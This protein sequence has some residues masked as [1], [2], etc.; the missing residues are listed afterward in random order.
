MTQEV[1][2]RLLL[3]LGRDRDEAAV[4][5][6]RL[7]ERLVFFFARRQFILAESLADEA[8]DRLANR[9]SSGERIEAP[10]SYAYGIARLVAQ[11]EARRSIRE[12]EANRHY[13]RNI[14]SVL[15]T[16]DEGEIHEAM[17]ACLGRHSE[18]DR[19]LLTEYYTSRG[20]ALI[21]HRRRMAEAL[22]MTPNAFRKRVFRLRRTLESCMRA[23]LSQENGTR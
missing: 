2:D 15:D 8:L 22:G 11:E 7:R 20:R 1:L 18:E 5:Y 4:R 9:L 19:K 3:A 12:A 17:E 21:D 16:Q 13:A 14:S 10:E 23:R 6:E